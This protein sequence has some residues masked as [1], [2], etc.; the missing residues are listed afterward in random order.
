MPRIAGVNIPEK[1]QIMIALT[2]IYGIG[3]SLAREI[4]VKAKI[5]PMK[6]SSQLQEKEI[7]KLREIIEGNY[8]TEGSLRRE[9]I[10]NIKR[11]KEIRCWRGIRHLRG[12]PVRGQKTRKN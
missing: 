7:G 6:K 3:N 8:K 4:L 10:G 9:I 1:K 2:Y 12:L 5:D 11:L